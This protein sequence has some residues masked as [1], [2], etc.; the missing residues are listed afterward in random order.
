MLQENNLHLRI[1][2]VYPEII[3]PSSIVSVN[4]I[5]VS[6]E[7]FY[8]LVNPLESSKEYD[9]SYHLFT[10]DIAQWMETKDIS[11]GVENLIA[12][13]SLKKS[14]YHLPFYFEN[15]GLNYS[16]ILASYSLFTLVG[17]LVVAVFLL[18]AGSFVYFKLQTALEREK[19]KFDALRR[20]G[21]TDQELKNLVSRYLFPQFFLPWAVA[22][23]HSTFAFLALQAIL[24]DVADLNIVKEVLFAYSFFVIIQVVY[25]YLIRWRYISHVR[26]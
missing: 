25:Y 20:M 1:D 10:F 7:D 16:Y 6:D 22:L 2:S 15:A 13:E 12:E 3:F 14:G 8:N 5:I 21:L 23:V 9:W 11:L 18:A 4:S 26:S 17:V 24:K 19:K